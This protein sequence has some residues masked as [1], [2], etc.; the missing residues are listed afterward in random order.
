MAEYWTPAPIWA[1]RTV[2]VVG[3]GPSLRGFDFER[4]RGRHVLAVNAGFVDLAPMA[5]GTDVLFFRD[6]EWFS[7]NRAALAGW[8][9]LIVTVSTAAKA[10]WPDRVDLVEA[11]T[12]AMP[13]ARTSGHQA[14]SLALMLG[15]GRIV[16]LGFDWN[17]EGGNYHD[18]HAR[19][20]LQYRGG[21][22]ESWRGYRERAAR[23]GA[24]IVNATRHT[25][26]R[27]F[28][29]VEQS[30]ELRERSQ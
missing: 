3:G 30:E 23:A 7:R 1:D 13:R 28:P 25:A 16:L 5:T 27:E 17:P 2:F 11:N 14:V 15:A 4:L 22:L 10:D 6:H 12:E 21:L 29:I 24:A 8:A 18:R 9:G 19:R 20:G 26:I